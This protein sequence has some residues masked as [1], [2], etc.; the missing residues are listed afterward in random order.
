M[1]KEREYNKG[2]KVYNLG[3]YTNWEQFCMTK[4]EIRVPL[5]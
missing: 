2:N 5:L 3:K 1:H 4:M